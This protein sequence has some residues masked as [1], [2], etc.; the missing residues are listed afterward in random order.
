[1]NNAISGASPAHTHNLNVVTI[2]DSR[3][4]DLDKNIV[5]LEI[6]YAK[7]CED[8]NQDMKF[9]LKIHEGKPELYDP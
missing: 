5:D 9:R 1:M 2:L 6:L 7:I 8:N 3:L 4:R